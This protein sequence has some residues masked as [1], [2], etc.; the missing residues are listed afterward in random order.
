MK[1]QSI[2]YSHRLSRKQPI[3]V[4]SILLVGIGNLVV[5][6][7]LNSTFFGN[8]LIVFLGIIAAIL[9]FRVGSVIENGW[10]IPF[11]TFLFLGFIPGFMVTEI[12]SYGE[13]KLLAF[14]IAILLVVAPSAIQYPNQSFGLLFNILIACSVLFSI[15]LLFNG[16][17]G[18]LGRDQ[19]EGLNPIGI[20]RV[21]AISSVLTL[22]L[23]ISNWR[24]S[25][26][27]R[28]LLLLISGIGLFATIAT[29]SRGPLVAAGV[30]L[31]LLGLVL[32]FLRR[33]KIIVLPIAA[34]FVLIL[35]FL[36]QKT[37]ARGF[38]RILNADD[39]G[40]NELYSESLSLAL[41]K[42]LGIGWG[43]LSDYISFPNQAIQGRLYSHNILLET[44]VEGGWIAFLA[45]VTLLFVAVINQCRAISIGITG[46]PLI[47]SMLIYLAIN[48][49]VSSD[50]VGNR[51]LWLFI[52]LSLLPN[53]NHSKRV[54][55]A[56]IPESYSREPSSGRSE[57]SGKTVR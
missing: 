22:S 8:Y 28:W 49:M 1:N 9:V 55:S 29:G 31:A 18:N 37:D 41:S 6:E 23:L 51:L 39:S 5:P 54:F 56:A 38:A 48:A 35:L 52:G 20:A 10:Y 43:N 30:A 16:I 34:I 19:I 44:A 50:I 17:Q 7:S 46:A 42:P 27:S 45:F 11:A 21:T 32:V 3:L 26:N 15:L 57:G 47:F 13:V 33:I 53:I 2:K 12:S 36:V 25:T 4:F 40:R 14:L 24:L